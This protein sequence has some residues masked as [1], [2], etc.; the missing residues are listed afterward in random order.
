MGNFKNA[1]LKSNI[2]HPDDLQRISDNQEI[3]QV[4][5]FTNEQLPE[6]EDWKSGETYQLKLRVKQ[7]RKIEGNNNEVEANFEIVA[8]KT[9]EKEEDELTPEQK[10]IKR[11][12]E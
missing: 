8:V 10:R 9:D 2:A 5:T 1:K 7:I 12:L 4:L 11:I 6:M 3:L